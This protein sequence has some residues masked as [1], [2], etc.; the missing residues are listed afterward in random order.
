MFT[1][2]MTM[3]GIERFSE[4]IWNKEVYG[5]FINTFCI[6]FQLSDVFWSDTEMN[7]FFITNEGNSEVEIGIVSK[8]YPISEWFDFI[9]E[10]M[11]IRH[12]SVI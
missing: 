6:G 4:I 2:K 7:V 9:A 10:M 11:L 1:G 12:T 8:R 3:T 5:H